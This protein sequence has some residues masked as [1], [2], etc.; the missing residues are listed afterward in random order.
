MSKILYLSERYT[1]LHYLY[2]KCKH[3][4]KYWMRTFISKVILAKESCIRTIHAHILTKPCQ[5][6][7]TFFT[8]MTKDW[9][10]SIMPALL[11]ANNCLSF[12]YIQK[13]CYS[14]LLL[15]ELLN[16]AFS[17]SYSKWYFSLVDKVFVNMF[18]SLKWLSELNWS[19]AWKSFVQSRVGVFIWI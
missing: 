12:K 3:M 5:L 17:C 16:Y 19:W 4:K 11:F 18:R 9:F 2:K 7:E 6:E 10:E 1:Y 13:S 8:C 15:I 14:I